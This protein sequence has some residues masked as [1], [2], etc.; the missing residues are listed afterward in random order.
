L[1]KLLVG[2]G[3]WAL[4]GCGSSSDG[5]ADGG[6]G[7]AAVGGDGAMVANDAAAGDATIAGDGAV[8]PAP[9]GGAP[10]A[11]DGA[12]AMLDDS[13]KPS[14][15]GMDGITGVINGKTYA[16]F[17][18]PRVTDSGTEFKSLLL[19]AKPVGPGDGWTI[20]IPKAVGVFPC[21]KNGDPAVDTYALVGGPDMQ[22]TA[23]G[24]PGSGCTVEVKSV[25][26]HIEGRFVA[27]LVG[28]LGAKNV[29]TSGYFYFSNGLADCS[30]AKDP[31]VPAGTDGATLAVTG[32]KGRS[33]VY[34]CGENVV[35][36]AQ[37][38]N[39]F[40]PIVTFTAKANNRDITLTIEGITATG[41]F[42]CGM[43]AVPMMSAR[44]V[45]V[46]LGEFMFI[47]QNGMNGGSCT[48]TVTQYDTSIAGTYSGTLWNSYTT[49][50]SELTVSGSFHIPRTLMP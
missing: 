34:F 19:E 32:L 26:G 14:L 15:T 31:G 39:A 20:T 44:N 41:T 43:P 47:K 9:D 18:N 4:V 22:G 7:D 38:S 3:L 46:S 28:F 49:D 42:P 10:P 1:N 24:V 5:T 29:V 16:Y 35:Y 11:T 2:I 13:G 25:V 21:G 12:T 50:H 30:Q 36:K 17:T 8:A 33:S 37:S 45:S 23:Y 48:V 6:A 40:E 27:V